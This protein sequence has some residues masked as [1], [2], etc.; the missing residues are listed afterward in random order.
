MQNISIG[1]QVKVVCTIDNY[2]DSGTI[3]K[4]FQKDNYTI[5]GYS[6]IDADGRKGSA[7]FTTQD[8]DAGITKIEILN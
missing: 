6:F 1:T 8:I 7:T 2:S 3:K 5:Y 4:I